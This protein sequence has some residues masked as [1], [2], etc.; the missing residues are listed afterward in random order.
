MKAHHYDHQGQGHPQDD[1]DD[2]DDRPSRSQLKRE[3]E[4]LQD[5]GEELMQLSVDT[6]KKFALPDNLLA[7]LLEA[8]KITANGAIRRQRQYI[9]KLMRSVDPTPIEAQLRI[10]RGENDQ[11]TAW[12]HRIERWR[13][14]LL[15]DD[16]A[17]DELMDDYA[18][19]DIQALRQAIRN[20]RREKAEARPPKAYRQIFQ[21]LRA[22]IPA[23]GV[24]A[25]AT[26]A[27]EEGDDDE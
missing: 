17:L 2:L 26:A 8:K 20:A 9:G 15:A 19:D 18:V 14:R 11:H 22:L 6:L 7:A 12:L 1:H 23:P 4:A 27:D 24:A 5:L 25:G 13:D 10:V 16:G 21:I 3:V